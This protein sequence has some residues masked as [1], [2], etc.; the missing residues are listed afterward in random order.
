MVYGFLHCHSHHSQM[1]S[2]TKI[3]ELC[4]TVKEMGAKAISLTTMVSA[5]GILNLW[6]LAKSMD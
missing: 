5:Q 6:M 2:T 1:D 4:K 3:D